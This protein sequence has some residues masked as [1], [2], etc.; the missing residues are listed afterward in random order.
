MD[1]QGRDYKSRPTEASFNLAYH[2]IHAKEF[3]TP[4]QNKM[5]RYCPSSLSKILS[6]VCVRM[7]SPKSRSANLKKKN[8]VK[9]VPVSVFF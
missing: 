6:H 5:V 4:P 2:V 1:A 7:L 9:S 3:S 8:V